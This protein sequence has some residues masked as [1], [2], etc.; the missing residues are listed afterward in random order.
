MTILASNN[1]GFGVRHPFKY[2]GEYSKLLLTMQLI[3]NDVCNDFM[4]SFYNPGCGARR[5]S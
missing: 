3:L 4:V 5:P 1:A 2:A